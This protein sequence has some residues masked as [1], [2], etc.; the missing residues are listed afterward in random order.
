[1]INS[2]T[3]DANDM[4]GQRAFWSFLLITLVAPLVVAVIVLLSGVTAG[5]TGYGPA[6]LLALDRG[7][8]FAWSAEHAMGAYVWSAIPAAVAA[9]VFAGLLLARLTHNWLVCASIA[10]ITGTLFALLAGGIIGQHIAPI[11]FIG[12]IVGVIMCR[13]LARIG[14]TR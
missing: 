9:A 14:I 1:M 2:P 3:H 5:L 13:L 7:G 10:A 12:A 8:K 11:A 6:S 4:I